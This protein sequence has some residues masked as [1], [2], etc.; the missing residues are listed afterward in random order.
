MQKSVENS[1][2]WCFVERIL[3]DPLITYLSG[4]KNDFENISY[5]TT[6]K[7]YHRSYRF[8][9]KRMSISC[10]SSKKKIPFCQN[11]PWDP[12]KRTDLDEKS[13]YQI[14]KTFL[15]NFYSLPHRIPDRPSSLHTFI[16]VLSCTS[17]SFLT[18]LRALEFLV[19]FLF[20]RC[21]V[22]NSS[23]ELITCTHS[24]A[25]LYRIKILVGSRAS[26]AHNVFNCC[27]SEN[28]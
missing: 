21:V 10:I 13:L 5:H 26:T 1:K 14:L 25:S 20:S 17:T 3:M 7:L 19:L 6:N 8:S 2:K 12:P 4:C 11:D 18:N 23:L 16:P 9:I 27:P 24:L 15:W 28:T 22:R